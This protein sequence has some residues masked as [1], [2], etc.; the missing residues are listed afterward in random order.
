MHVPVAVDCVCVHVLMPVV[1]VVQTQVRGSGGGRAGGQPYLCHLHEGLQPSGGSFCSCRTRGAAGAG[2]VAAF[3]LPWPAVGVGSVLLPT[4]LPC[5]WHTS[6]MQEVQ[7]LSL[8]ALLC[9]HSH[10]CPD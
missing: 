10:G 7:V 4:L 2:P 8:A 1:C 5:P 3:H 9:Q 6:S